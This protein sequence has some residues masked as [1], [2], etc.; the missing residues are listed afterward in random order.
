MYSAGRLH[1]HP[2]LGG[3]VLAYE[4]DL[5]GQMGF[6]VLFALGQDRL[7]LTTERTGA[8]DRGQLTGS[9]VC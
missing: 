4:G 2:D 9:G 5:T 7:G 8:N 1:L 3:A 6:P